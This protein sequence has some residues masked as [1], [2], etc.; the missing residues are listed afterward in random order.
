MYMFR[1]EK[2]NLFLTSPTLSQSLSS[3]PTWNKRI[4]IDVLS[5]D[6]TKEITV[7]RGSGLFLNISFVFRSP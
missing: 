2:N 3:P 7:K 5:D 1:D 4:D 6:E